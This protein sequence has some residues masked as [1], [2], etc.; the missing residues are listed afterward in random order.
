MKKRM[1]FLTLLAAMAMV[2]AACSSDSGESTTSAP[3]TT[4]G[5]ATT[6]APG[7]TEP[8]ATG[9][10]E[11]NIGMILLGVN[12]EPWYST[13]I[14][15]IGRLTAEKPHG[16]DINLE[17]FENV[18]YADGERVIR[19]L[20][21]S[22]KYQMII[23]H[24]AY[25][26]G[27]AAVK[28]EFPDILFAYSGSGNDPLGGNGYWVDVWI[29]EPAYL[30]GIVAGMM[31]K[32][33]TISGV[34]AFPFPNVNGPLNA[35]IQ[36]ARSVNPDVQ[37]SVT[38]IESWFDPAAAKE[39][40]VAQIAADSDM[41][42]ME[43]FGPL[44]AIEQNDGVYGFGHFSDQLALD[45][46]KVLTSPV[47]MWDPAV[48]TLIEAWWAHMTEDVPYDAPMERIMFFMPA[49]GASLGAMSDVVPDDVK[50]AVQAAEDKIMSGELV[51]EFNDA[52]IE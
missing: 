40:A 42:Y 29:H 22:G 45:P 26:D 34:A 49:G 27:V 3:P 7:S 18:A 36:G 19:D 28:D 13:M 12:L 38:Y 47:A 48:S 21:S 23:A 31:T 10:T 52:P 11:L 4:G 51:V 41:V 9:P 32:T 35:W 15:S 50:A 44:E 30:A 6:A 39:A 25:S 2:V 46:A 43:R 33:N 8:A 14:D 24:S 20:A 17:I 1:R 16:L 37:A 5:V